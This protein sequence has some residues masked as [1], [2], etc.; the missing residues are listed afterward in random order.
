MREILFRGKPGRSSDW[1]EGDLIQIP[2][3]RVYIID[4]KFGA[5]IDDKG[6]LINSE[7]PFVCEVLPETVGQYTNL[8]DID[9]KRIFEGDIVKRRRD[10]L[11]ATVV[12]CNGSWELWNWTDEMFDD[13]FLSNWYN[14]CSYY[15]EEVGGCYVIGNVHD[16]PAL[17]EMEKTDD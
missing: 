11:I 9:D 13:D 5:C 7:Y 3:G 15:G 17:L 16:N 4:N 12:L 1:V 6:N 10:G 2:G 8:K 14:Q